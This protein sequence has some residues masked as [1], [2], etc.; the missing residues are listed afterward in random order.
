MGQFL[1]W[2]K[3]VHVL[4]YQDWVKK[5]QSFHLNPVVIERL[6]SR[7]VTRHA[8]LTFILFWTGNKPAIFM[9]TVTTDRLETEAKLLTG[10]WCCGVENLN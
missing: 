8:Q 4:L 10:L 9:L 3:H 7:T 2:I 1:D 6:S 5:K